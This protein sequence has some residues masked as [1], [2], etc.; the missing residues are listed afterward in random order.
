[1]AIE[2]TKTVEPPRGWMRFL[3]RLPIGLYRWHLG[4]LLGGRFVLI[5]HIGRNSGLPRQVVVEVVR[6]DKNSH[7]IIVASGFGRKAQWYQNLRKTPDV[8]IQLGTRKYAARA[9]FLSAEQG[10]I[11]MENYARR[12]PAAARELAKFMGYRVDGTTEDYQ[13]LGQE[14]PFVALKYR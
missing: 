2:K 6:H 12:H 13:I 10:A 4:W 14:I 1:M 8:T 11:E 7:T 5:N 9:E 3:A